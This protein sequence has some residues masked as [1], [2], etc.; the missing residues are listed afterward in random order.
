MILAASQV[1]VHSFNVQQESFAANALNWRSELL[2]HAPLLGYPVKLGSVWTLGVGSVGTAAL[3]FLTLAT[4][5]FDSVLIDMDRVKLHNITRSPIF[6]HRDTR[7]LKVNVTKAFLNGA[8]VRHVLTDDKPLDESLLW[9]NRESGK[10]DVVIA[11]A[12]SGKPATTSKRDFRRFRSMPPPARIGRPHCSGTCPV[13]SLVPYVS[14]RRIKRS[15]RPPVQQLQTSRSL[16][17]MV[18]RSMHPCR[19]FRSRRV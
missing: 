3:Y 17:T 18:S 9:L 15:Q 2:S 13:R 7:E 12:T 8:G 16:L 4:R 11:A 10:A 14:F 1:F 5:D 19:F 6:A